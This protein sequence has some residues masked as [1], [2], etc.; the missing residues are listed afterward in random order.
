MAR[1]S[2][3]SIG[4]EFA[5]GAELPTMGPRLNATVGSPVEA[6]LILH[7]DRTTEVGIWEVTPG[8]FPAGKEG[9][10]ELMQFISG[11][12]TITDASGVTEIVPGVVMFTPDGWEGIWDVEETI[13]KTYALHQTRFTLRSVARVMLARLRK[14]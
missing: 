4:L 12:G 6:K 9:V 1:N 14:R 5:L 7:S 3:P 2:P 8:S 13:R 10:W 11:R